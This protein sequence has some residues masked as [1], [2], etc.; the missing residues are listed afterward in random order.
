VNVTTG[1]SPV[2]IP[3]SLTA[4]ALTSSSVRLRWQDNASNET[5]FI[6][7]RSTDP[8]SGF[9]QLA[10]KGVNVVDHM[11]VNLQGNTTYYYKIQATSS[12]G[13]SSFTAAVSVTTPKAI[14]AAPASLTAMYEE[15]SGNITLAWV[16]ASSNEDNFV[17]EKSFNGTTFAVLT[18]TTNNTYTDEDPG[19]TWR[20]LYRVAAKN[21]GGN[22]AYSNV[23]Q[24]VITGVEADAD[25]AGLKLYPNPVAGKL[26]VELS[27]PDRGQLSVKFYDL[28]GRELRT[29]TYEKPHTVFVEQ[30]DVEDMTDRAILVMKISIGR[31]HVTRKVVVK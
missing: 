25:M 27:S 15:A 22:S 28:T 14:P 6:I 2:N 26:T 7:T 24:V 5:G 17:I 11:D 8:T 12:S 30:V 1:I 16:D 3:T 13:S 20:V 18:E 9:T 4:E 31:K 29:L 21:S 10:T 19:S 23:A